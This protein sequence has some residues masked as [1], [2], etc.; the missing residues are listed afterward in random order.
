MISRFAFILFRGEMAMGWRVPTRRLG[1]IPSHPQWPEV[2]QRALHRHRRSDARRHTTAR[3]LLTSATPSGHDTCQPLGASYSGVIP[4]DQSRA[5][6][7]SGL[8]TA[9][10]VAAGTALTILPTFLFWFVADHREA[11][12]VL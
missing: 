6:A 4:E 1:I 9:L 10:I 3:R 11:R 12:F 5:V 7:R 8:R 2:L